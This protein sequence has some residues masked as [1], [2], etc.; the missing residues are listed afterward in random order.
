M[1]SNNRLNSLAG[2]LGRKHEGSVASLPS[3]A[4]SCQG[5]ESYLSPL[6]SKNAGSS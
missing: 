3:R 1:N 4:F 5:K 6:I 2:S